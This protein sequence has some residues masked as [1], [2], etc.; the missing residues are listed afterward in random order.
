MHGGSIRACSAKAQRLLLWIPDG[1]RSAE[2]QAAPSE[3]PQGLPLRPLGKTGLEV[4]LQASCRLSMS[5]KGPDNWV[6][7]AVVKPLKEPR[8]SNRV[9]L[10]GFLGVGVTPTDTTTEAYLNL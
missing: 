5:I 9:A 4:Y 1:V 6:F 3:E 10:F 2:G 8:A 7:T